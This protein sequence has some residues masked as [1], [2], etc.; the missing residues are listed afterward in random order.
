MYVMPDGRVF[1]S[2][3]AEYPIASQILN[4]TTGTWSVVDPVPVDGGS[5]V[6]YLPGKIMKSGTSHDPDRPP[7]PSTNR[8]YVIDMTAP[9]PHWVETAP[10]AFSRTYHN[11][12]SLPDG[13]VLVTGGGSTSD[14]VALGGARLMAEL[15]NPTT[16]TY[17]SLSAGS[18]PRLYHSWAML[19]PDA[20]VLVGAGGRFNGYPSNDPSDML[21]AEIYS[22][23]Y[24]FKG[25]RPVISSAPQSANVNTSITVQT[26]QA[27]S[28]ASVSLIRL[29]SVTHAFNAD[30]RF[31]PLSFTA[32]AGQLSVQMPANSNLAP[33]GYYM[34][35]IVDGNGVPSTAAIM[36]V[37]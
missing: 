2:S 17:T 20:R 10:M 16:Q 21:N 3:T 7:D 1:A 5:S 36:R 32:G 24:L 8:T 30:G 4:L 34:L 31:V 29:A 33:P 28:I 19:L 11:L 9:S 15:W 6:M 37:Q 22:P 27:A 14:A 23:P 13:N 35:F 12:T 25:A 26:P 18:V